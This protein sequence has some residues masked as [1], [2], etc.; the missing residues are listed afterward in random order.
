MATSPKSIWSSLRDI[1]GL[2]IGLGYAATNP[3]SHA[4]AETAVKVGGA[5]AKHCIVIHGQS[6]F[7]S[8]D[9]KKSRLRSRMFYASQRCI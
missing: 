7:L 4:N 2:L 8:G 9:G 5:T 6:T 1:E 3:D